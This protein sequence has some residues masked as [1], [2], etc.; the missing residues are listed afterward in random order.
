MKCCFP[1]LHTCWHAITP[2]KFPCFLL[3]ATSPS[4]QAGCA[5]PRVV[6]QFHYLLWP[7]H[8]VPR[9]SAQLLCLVDVVN[10]RALEVPAGP[11]VVHCR[12]WAGSSWVLGN[13]AR[14]ALTPSCLCPQRRDWAHWY[15]HRP[16]LP[17]EDG[18]GRG[19]GRCVSLRAEA[20]GAAHQHGA[21]QGE[22]S[23]LFPACCQAADLLP[24]FPSQGLWHENVTSHTVYGLDTETGAAR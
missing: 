15:L 13:L 16:G 20:A 22:E 24:L 1:L 17:P 4:L 12:Y 19:E 8:G 14:A 3:P 21:D 9:N 6:E 11:V 10:K 18:E 5:F 7:D 2:R 23:V